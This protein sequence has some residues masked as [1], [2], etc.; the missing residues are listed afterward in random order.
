MNQELCS[1][2]YLVFSIK[3]NLTVEPQDSSYF[4]PFARKALKGGN[5]R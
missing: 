2:E 4:L 5:K 3:T 1:I